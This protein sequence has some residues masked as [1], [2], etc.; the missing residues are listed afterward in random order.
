MEKK[1]SFEKEALVV[2]GVNLK[3]ELAIYDDRIHLILQQFFSEIS[4]IL[5]PFIKAQDLF[6]W[7][8]KEK[9]TRYERHGQFRLSAVIDAQLCKDKRA[10]GNCL[11]LTLLYNCLLRKMGIDA[12]ALYLEYAFGIGPH[13]LT[14]LQTEEST[15]DIDNILPYGFDYKGHLDHPSRTR[16]GDRELVADIFNSLGNECFEK[17]EFA[18]ALTNYEMAIKL[19]PQYQKARLN[20]AI[21]MNKIRGNKDKVI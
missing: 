19:N 13:V 5:D 16:W 20:K 10:V 12:E 17:G 8:W 1:F 14:L 21:L 3:G 11:G 2:S 9:P 18:K 4:P 6:N 15:I 7:L